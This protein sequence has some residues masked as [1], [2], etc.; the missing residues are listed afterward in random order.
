MKLTTM[1]HDD[2]NALTGIRW[3]VL[4]AMRTSPRHYLHATLEE[5]ADTVAF[6]VGRAGHSAILEPAR[7]ADDFV[8][9]DKTKQRRGKVWD[10][11]AE[12]HHGRTILNRAEYENAIGMS[13]AVRNPAV[14]PMA[15]ELFGAT[16]VL[17]EVA[18]TWCDDATGLDCKALLDYFDPATNTK[19][20]LKSTRNIEPR[21]FGHD[22]ARFGYHCQDAFHSRGLRAAGHRIARHLIVA[23]ENAPPFDVVV[24]EVPGEVIEAAEREVTKLLVRVKDCLARTEAGHP[25]PWPGVACDEV[26]PL[27]L[28]PWALGGDEPAEMTL[29]G[30]RVS[31]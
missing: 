4:R 13:A 16:D 18:S 6:R 29:G 19:V 10:A 21:W 14:N 27:V 7:F 15:A 1:T 22:A 9:Y 20:E 24:H 28:P 30:E 8:V 25:Q 23:V 11:F 31:V 17:H 12:E 5:R 26:V 3:S 2:Y